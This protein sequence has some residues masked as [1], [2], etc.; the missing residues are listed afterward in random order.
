MTYEKTAKVLVGAGLLDQAD[1][2]AAV[3]ALG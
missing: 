2:G 3:A 1:T